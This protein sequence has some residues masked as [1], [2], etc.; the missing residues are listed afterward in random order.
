MRP[1]PF[2]NST[3]CVS[4][5]SL[6]ASFITFRGCSFPAVHI[7]SQAEQES[8]L[9]V[10]FVD[11]EFRDNRLPNNVNIIRGAGVRIECQ[12]TCAEKRVQ[13]QITRCEFHNN[14]AD[15]GGGIYSLNSELRVLDSSFVNNTGYFGGS[16][17]YS[18]QT[19]GN[20][21]H[22]TVVYINESRFEDNIA[23][24]VGLANDLRDSNGKPLEIVTYYTFT[25]PLATGGACLF[26]NIQNTTI[27]FSDFTQNRA[28]AGGAISY[29]YDELKTLDDTSPEYSINN[30]SFN[31]NAATHESAYYQRTRE[32]R[33][34]GALHIALN[35]DDVKMKILG[36]NFTSN[37]AYHGGAIHLVASNA[38]EAEF[39]ECRFEE[40][41]AHETGGAVILRYI[42]QLNWYSC[43]ATRNLARQGGAVMVTNQA[44][45]H[46]RGLSVN[47]DETTNG[48]P[49]VFT[50][51][52]AL[53]GGA[54]MCAGC[55]PVDI[56]HPLLVGNNARRL[57]GAVYVLECIHNFRIQHVTAFNNQALVGGAFAAES[58][59]LFS[60]VTD[61]NLRGHVTNNT[62]VMGGAVFYSADR[63]RTNTVFLR[64]Q[65]FTGNH[66]VSL[67]SL[68]EFLLETE[69]RVLRLE[70]SDP[71]PN[72]G[73]ERL[74]ACGEGGGGAV[75]IGLT[76]APIRSSF[77]VI[78][79]VSQFRAN[80]AE[81]GGGV[82]I[83]IDTANWDVRSTNTCSLTASHLEACR[84]VTF[85]EVIVEDNV[86]TMGGGGAFVSDPNYVDCTC[87]KQN[88]NVVSLKDVID[89]LLLNRR[90][91]NVTTDLYCTQFVDNSVEDRGIYGPHVATSAFSIELD[92]PLQPFQGINSGDPNQTSSSEEPFEY[93]LLVKDAFDQQITGGRHEAQLE[94][95]VESNLIT[96]QSR[97]GGEGGRIIINATRVIAIAS[98]GMPDGSKQHNL[99][100]RSISNPDLF[101]TTNFTF[102]SCYAGEV[103]QSATCSECPSNYFSFGVGE[104][105]E[106]DERE[107]EEVCLPCPEHAN[108]TGGADL[109]PE[110]GYWHATPFSPHFHKCLVNDA[111]KY[112]NRQENLTAF[113][114]NLSS[115]K[116]STDVLN[117][118]MYR[119]C[120]D[121]Y[122][123]RLC[124][125]CD[126]GYGRLSDGECISCDSRKAV[127][128][129]LIVILTFWIGIL[130][131]IEIFNTLHTNHEFKELKAI[132]A[133]RIFSSAMIP[134]GNCGPLPSQ[135]ITPVQQASR[136][137]YQDYGMNPGP[138]RAIG[139]ATIVMSDNIPPHIAASEKL[140]ELIKILINFMQIT[141]VA[142]S[143]NLQW[144][145]AIRYILR[146][147]E[148]LTGVTHGTSYLP[149]E[150]TLED[151]SVPGSIAVLWIRVSFPFII[152]AGF[153]ML[154]T[155]YW[156]AVRF[157]Y[158]RRNRGQV[159]LPFGD[160]T[161]Y[162]IV[163]II[164]VSFFS[165][166]DVTE[167]LMRTLNCINIDSSEYD[168]DDVDRLE[169][170]IQFAVAT[171][172]YWGED[173]SLECFEGDHLVTGVFGILGLA[174]FSFG[175]VLFNA[176]LL[177]KNFHVIGKEQFIARYG[178][179]YRSYRPLWYTVPWES[180]ISIRK[181]LVSAAVVYAF[182]LGRNLQAVM[183]LGVLILAQAAHL[184]C[185]PFKDYKTCP[186][187]PDYAGHHFC[188][189]CRGRYQG[190]WRKLND[191]ITLNYLESASLLTS[192]IT[193]YSGIVFNDDQTSDAGIVVMTCFAATVNIGFFVYMIYRL[194]YAFHVMV[195][196]MSSY[197]EE[198]CELESGF[199]YIRGPGIVA[200]LKRTSQ[201]IRY[202]YRQYMRKP[203][204]DSETSALR[205]RREG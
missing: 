112:D 38:V 157:L 50:E 144:Q 31:G 190:A 175:T 125:S 138:S 160:L 181:A 71:L 152:L 129:V 76:N 36:S 107:T 54:I 124:A 142:V 151:N 139:E 66:A 132:R 183:A 48:I 7:I 90:N 80:Q 51:N 188:L 17:I 81:V 46:V 69:R 140:T 189:P 178:F 114:A 43:N 141:S 122:K 61:G 135:S 170:Y 180:V 72:I 32:V 169:Q 27:E 68:N 177:L 92:S 98:E 115:L 131:A 127:T 158:K 186:S 86:A 167:E 25:A 63:Q 118:T 14:I 155:F 1:C 99:T 104:E 97:Y 137:I 204:V 26:E 168:Q 29:I 187:L 49:S 40:N 113:Y 2:S 101:V 19:F 106:R 102:R 64:G 198:T 42:G 108:C 60:V 182:R 77:D 78:L 165:Y 150:C 195:N 145:S 93:V 20:S 201:L 174:F 123:S 130:V 143:M 44:G 55:G 56:Q 146:F 89:T 70:R 103:W 128:I 41:Y 173:T 28:A 24:R 67:S 91:L 74:D 200:L 134:M 161:T 59:E 109:S 176:V 192:M 205:V 4:S 3:N 116:P 13:L 73:D 15:R 185:R 105:E 33:L 96:G 16:A 148:V 75:C 191:K 199:V 156:I 5:T 126:E 163:T 203:A 53:E 95:S 10:E 88:T 110:E 57:G 12:G 153:L 58:A 111:C 202:K 34:G 117:N 45:F 21:S 6:T 8:D 119:Q 22:G 162:F 37:E 83:S 154:G 166:K 23:T 100:F 94:V 171:D 194:Y 172:L 35:I 121:G 159:Q 52:E 196:E 84:G 149:L 164:A 136:P 79:E 193:F 133:S 47:L 39:E 18:T 147:H 197:V 85:R 87:D 11:C 9:D 62:A 184:T 30:C 65:I 82:Y 120:K 179:L